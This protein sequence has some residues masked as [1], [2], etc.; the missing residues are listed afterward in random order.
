MHTEVLFRLRRPLPAPHQSL[1]GRARKR[2]V[3]AALMILMALTYAFDVAVRELAPTQASRF[4]G[5]EEAWLFSLACPGLLIEPQPR[6]LRLAARSG[7]LRALR[8]ARAFFLQRVPQR[9]A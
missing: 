9:P 4:A 6:Y 1:R 2:G 8:A 7:R 5:I 3:V